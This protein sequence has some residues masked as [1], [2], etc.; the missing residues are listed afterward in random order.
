MNL[1][2]SS[3][4]GKKYQN[5]VPTDMGG[6]EI[7]IPILKEY[8]T[9]KAENTPKQT[10]GPFKT[11]T[12]VYQIPPAAGL[13]VT[14]IGHSSILIEIDGKTI[15]TDPVWSDRVSFSSFFGPKRFFAPPLQ[16]D[17]LPPLDAIIISHDHYDHLD[18]QTIKYY[19]GKAIPFFCSMGVGEHLKKW[20]IDDRFITELDWGDS[21]MLGTDCKITTT[22]ARHF[23]GRGITGRNE[24]LWSSFVIK[25]AKH[26]IFFG[27]DS[28][29]FPGFKAIG[30]AYG[31]FDLTIL[32]IGAYGKHWPD[33]HMG[34]DHASNAHLALNGKLMM[35]IHYG[36]FNLAPH[37]WYEPI[38]R[39]VNYGKE[40]NIN[41]FI[42]GPG[43]TAEVKGAYNSYW[44]KQY[45]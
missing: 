44:W 27:A 26:N 21:A 18:K 33:I 34:P 28:G 16:L 12:S 4:K 15:L 17:E 9:N 24:T 5:P 3:K 1:S 10:L 23:S 20:G 32:E 29:W 8:A 38:E 22:P 11:D 7:M 36:T 25:G 13:R 37:A 6:F 14:W 43:E 40:K 30:D 31:P 35:P 41:L 39:L 45:L 42:P 2:S 19:A